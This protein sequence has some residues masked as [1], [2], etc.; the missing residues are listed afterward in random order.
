[1][2]LAM[3]SRSEEP[4]GWLLAAVLLATFGVRTFAAGQPLVENYVGRQVPT[5]MVARNLERGSGFLDPRL[6]VAPLPNRFLVEPPVYEAVVVG[7]RR[8]T[9]LPLDVSGR[10]VSA[11]GMVLAAWGTYGLVAVRS[12]RRAGLLAAVALGLFPVTIR[13]GRAFQPDAL[14]LGTLLAGLR[15][16]DRG[17]SVGRTG[18]TVA[19]MV[20]VSAGLALKVLSAFVL[21]PLLMLVGRRGRLWRVGMVA[22]TLV[23]ALLWYVHAVGLLPTGHGSSA[24]ADNGAIWLRSVDPLALL[25]GSTLRNVGRFLVV[26]C[27]TPIGLPLALL[28]LLGPNRGTGDRGFWLAWGAAGLATMAVLGPKLH[29][30]YYWLGLAPV[31]AAGVGM[32]LASL[33]EGGAAARL[34]AGALGIGLLCLSVTMSASTWRIPPE[35]R[36][37]VLAGEA[38]RAL[39]ESEALLA[40]PEALLY[41]SD[42]R[43]CRIEFTQPAARRA[44][45]EWRGRAPVSE[46]AAVDGP[47]ALVEFYRRRGA[48][49]F[50]DVVPRRPDPARKDLHESVRR[51]YNVVMDRDGVFIAL[52]TAPEDGVHS[53][54]HVDRPH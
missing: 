15:C 2:S 40:A 20:L 4:G 49:Y 29:H 18:W 16:W 35:W 12:G 43:G 37:I 45:G 26:R 6:D 38:V 19:G 32:A 31:I 3:V 22:A 28:G 7:F 8:I 39:V 30:E 33:I 21:V 41:Q 5:A 42:R 9:R 52:L 10:V 48:R 46:V 11:L 36:S 44:A 1:M 50:A 13:Y 14:M 24:S 27:F 53:T 17:L 54:D 51:R 23:P 34:G 47:A 25:R